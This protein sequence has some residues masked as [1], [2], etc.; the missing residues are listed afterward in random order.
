MI[1]CA[2][3]G[4]RM[5][6]GIR[7][8]AK[9]PKC[10]STEQVRKAVLSESFPFGSTR[11]FQREVMEQIEAALA[12]K[13]K[14][15]LL[16]A[17]VG[18]GKSAVAAALCR[19]LGTAYLLT[20][21]KQLQ[22]QYSSDFS[23][24]PVIGKSNFTC[25]VPTSTGHHVACNKGRCEV[26]WTLDE[27]PHYLSFEEYDEHKRGHHTKNS[28]CEHL[29]DRKL[30]PYYEQKWDAF[31]AKIVVAN[32]SFFLSELQYTDDVTKRKLL[33]CDEAHDLE[34]HLVGFASYSLKRSM[35]E[36]YRAGMGDKNPVIPL[37]GEDDAAAWLDVLRNSNEVLD[38][39]IE[40]R[41]DDPEMQ[42]KVA[43]AKGAQRSLE[44]FIEE[45]KG[46]PTNWV[47][48]KVRRVVNADG[49]DSVEEVVFQPLEVGG[50]TKELFGSA[51]TVMLM[52]ATLSSDELLCRTFGMTRDDACFI[53][54]PD[55]TFPVENRR[56]HAMDIAYLNRASMDSSLESITKAIDGI[57]DRHSGERG[58]VHTTSYQQANYIIDHIS[59]FN[60]ARLVSTEG[61]SSRSAL[62]KTHGNTG[63][64]VLISPS[65]YQGVD[66]KD[67][68]SRF[69]VVVKVP[70]PDLSERRTRVKL[71]KDAAWY[72]WQTALRL[73][74]TYGRSV[75][76]ETDHATT[77][78]LDSNFTRFVAKNRDL[79]PKYFLDA[80]QMPNAA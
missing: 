8:F 17:P 50:Y 7:G 29:K 77:Y 71:D 41:L 14:F 63:A 48:N 56:I 34:K 66:L 23:F 37:R 72:D 65:L 75:R 3:C 43:T 22:D 49:T 44:G 32:Y 24:P 79:F 25:C 4:T 1:F 74:Q 42:D 64:S 61:S 27:C 21:T 33:V 13:K 73:V 52:S 60:R 39:F 26:D 36:S 53:R 16:E 31:R 38:S 70:Y 68:M 6:T 69:Q 5:K 57:M 80:L 19:H 2:K 30:C 78:V 12:A 40:T 18:F 47:V 62:L 76:S 9:C 15:I 58:V 11:P 10:G 55:S 45:L 20:S 35:L 46:S 54:I 59:A 28:K 67:D 51:D